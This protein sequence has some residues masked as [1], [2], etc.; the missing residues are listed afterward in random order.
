MDQQRF[1]GLQTGAPVQPEPAGLVADVQGRRLGVVQGF[2]GRQQGRLVGD[3]VLGEASVR[4]GGGGE[5]PASVRRLA[6]DL[7]AGGEGQRW[8]HLVLAAAE[9]RVGEV[10]V[11]RAYRDQHLAFPGGRPVRL[12]EL[13]HLARLAVPVHSPCLHEGPPQHCRHYHCSGAY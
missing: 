11:R 2:G 6:A 1:T 13:H 10:D 8:P 7:D 5:H 4:E 12:L 9:Q 3:D